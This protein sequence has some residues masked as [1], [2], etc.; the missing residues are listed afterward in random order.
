MNPFVVSTANTADLGSIR[1][2]WMTLMSLFDR[3]T[4]HPNSPAPQP[5]W[6]IPLRDGT[7]TKSSSTQP[8]PAK[9]THPSKNSHY[10]Y[11]NKQQRPPHPAPSPIIPAHVYGGSDKDINSRETTKNNH[12]KWAIHRRPTQKHNHCSYT[13]TDGCFTKRCRTDWNQ[14]RQD[15]RGQT[16]ALTLTR[17]TFSSVCVCVYLCVSECI[18]IRNSWCIHSLNAQEGF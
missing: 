15:R 14:N 4:F 7:N 16:T 17:Q 1:V 12:S 6:C 10:S 13:A 11:T 9:A 5:T 2:T 18:T 8:A 3:G